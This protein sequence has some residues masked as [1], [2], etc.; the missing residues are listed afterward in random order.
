MSPLRCPPGG[1]PFGPPGS[2]CAS[3]S[4]VL[5]LS[6]NFVFFWV[7]AGGYDTMLPL[8]AREGLGLSTVA[9]GG[10][11]AIAV[12]AEMVA[13]YPAGIAADRIGRTARAHPGDSWRSRSPWPRWGGP[14]PR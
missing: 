1:G 10:V 14:P 9:V 11:F 4:F 12:L 13:V 2:C 8:F 7:V 3:R 6:L 5:V